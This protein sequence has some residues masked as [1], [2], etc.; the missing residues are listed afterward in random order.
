MTSSWWVGGD[1]SMSA[2]T[3]VFCFA[4][5]G[6]SASIYH[7]WNRIEPR[8]L[9]NFCGVEYPGRGTR[10]TERTRMVI[11]DLVQDA[12]ERI[13]GLGL[14]RY[15]LFGHSMGG[16]VAFETARE[17]VRQGVRQPQHLFISATG[18]PGAQ[19]ECPRLQGASDATVETELLA[20]GGTDPR[21][22]AE[23]ALRDYAISM[24]RAD[25]SALENYRYHAGENLTCPLTTFSSEGD[26]LVSPAQMLAWEDFTAGQVDHRL[27]TGDHFFIHTQATDLVHTINDALTVSAHQG[28]LV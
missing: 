23:P 18:A 9:A 28:S 26:A 1:P 10:Y 3:P 16:L 11:K 24:I 6:G 27:M 7:G 13:A 21:I 12:T 22:L 5:A 15:A 14:D 4:Y 25:Y 2:T 20:L 19:S 8:R 17:L